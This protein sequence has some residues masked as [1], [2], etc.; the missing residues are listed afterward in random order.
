M[1][2]GLC[3]APATFQ[4]AITKAFQEYIREFMQVF[5]DDFTIYGDAANHLH[6]LENCLC[7]C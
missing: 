1:P 2:F 4:W 3:N 7:Q 6:L 5:L